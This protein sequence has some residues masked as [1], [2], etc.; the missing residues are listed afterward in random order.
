LIAIIAGD[1]G[2]LVSDENERK[3]CNAISSTIDLPFHVHV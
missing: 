2:L 3:C 1:Y